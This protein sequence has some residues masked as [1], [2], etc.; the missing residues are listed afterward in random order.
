VTGT[1]GPAR[2]A[3]LYLLSLASIA[4]AEIAWR[5]AGPL[6]VAALA[7]LVAGAMLLGAVL[8]DALSGTIAAGVRRQARL[9][10]YGLV[11]IVGLLSLATG[12]AGATLAARG[13]EVLGLLLLATLLLGEPLRLELLAVWGTLLLTLLAALGGGPPALIGLPAWL[14][15]AGL[16]FA[17]DHA[18]RT[19][20]AWPA[21][22]PPRT[23]RLALDAARVLALPLLLLSAGLIALP[24]ARRAAPSLE[25]ESAAVLP[26]IR[27]SYEWLL[28]VALAGGGGVAFVFRWLRGDEKE[29]APLVEMAESRV[30]A[31]EALE[32]LVFEDA[33]YAAGRGRIIKAYVRFLEKARAAGLR[34]EP[35]LTAREIEGRVR[36]PEAPL[37]ALTDIF[38]AA[39]YGPDEPSAAAVHDAE[40]ASQILVR[41]LAPRARPFARARARR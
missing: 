38:T 2:Q 36:R 25:R 24:G 7:G 40:S 35:S 11:P 21:A 27:R 23:S 14:A 1:R 20:A 26:E 18:A 30:E 3:T 12:L 37:G 6:R 10:L 22:R 16:F 28:I 41:A 29:G 39:R 17:F 4:G 19:L 32:P 31:E 13:A 5:Q 34:L 33:R 9:V 15:L 8:A